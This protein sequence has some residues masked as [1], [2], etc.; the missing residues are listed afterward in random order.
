[1]SAFRLIILTLSLFLGQAYAS[2][3]DFQLGNQTSRSFE[4]VYITASEDKDWSGNLLNADQ[5]LEPRGLISVAF[6]PSEK[7]ATWDV[8]VV[9]DEGIAVTFKAV[10]LLNVDTITLSSVNGKYTAE[11]D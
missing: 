8:K 3:L 7:S 4:A 11:V 1:M 6:D 2:D 9:D 10:N 5:A